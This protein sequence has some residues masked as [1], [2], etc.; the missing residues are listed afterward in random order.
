MG[1]TAT[2]FLTES[3]QL[4]GSGK[5]SCLIQSTFP[6]AIPAIPRQWQIREVSITNNN[7]VMIGA[8]GGL[9]GVGSNALGQLGLLHMECV[10]K[11]RQLIFPGPP[12][13]P[14]FGSPQLGNSCGLNNVGGA[15]ANCVAGSCGTSSENASCSTGG[16]GPRAG[17]G[18]GRVAGRS[19]GAVVAGRGAGVAVAA[20]RGLIGANIGCG[21]I[22]KDPCFN[23]LGYGSNPAY[24]A[25]YLS[26]VGNYQVSNWKIY[27]SYG[28]CGCN[29]AGCGSCGYGKGRVGRGL[30]SGP[31]CGGC[32]LG[33]CGLGFCNGVG[34]GSWWERSNYPVIFDNACAGPC[35]DKGC[36]VGKPKGPTGV[37][38]NAAFVSQNSYLTGRVA[39]SK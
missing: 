18:A 20:G 39:Y 27:N 3:G 5:W 24:C 11:P 36:F 32:G 28:F 10:P 15:V 37:Y 21:N 9:F 22:C 38:E 25:D 29:G 7:I 17:L 31:G 14:A 19:A 30:C 13:P 4:Y 6:L 12:Q 35:Y 34:V 1:D 8:N 26:P 2:I 16:C 23:K 33:G